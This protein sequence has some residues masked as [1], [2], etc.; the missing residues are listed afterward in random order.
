M[1]W[2]ADHQWVCKVRRRCQGCP[3]DER[4]RHR[5]VSLALCSSSFLMLRS[6]PPQCL[7]LSSSHLLSDE[8]WSL[9]LHYVTCLG[10]C[11]FFVGLSRRYCFVEFHTVAESQYWMEVHQVMLLL[12]LGLTGGECLASLGTSCWEHY[13]VLAPSWSVLKVSWCTL[14]VEFIFERMGLHV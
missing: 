12:L 14:D 1:F 3:T 13:Q 8:K 4:K 11:W 10:D 5:F 9:Y 2:I 7:L 6:P